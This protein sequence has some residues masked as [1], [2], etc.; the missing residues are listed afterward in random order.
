MGP[1]DLIEQWP[2]PRTGAGVLV[3]TSGPAGGSVE[4]VGTTGNLDTV[5]GWAS[6]TKLLVS[7]AVLVTCDRDKMNLDDPAGPPGAT[8]RH[9]LSHASGLG[10][11]SA[12]PLVEPGRRRIYSNFGIEVLARH[13]E[14]RSSL[15][16]ADAVSETVTSPL[17]M[18]TMEFPPD[19]SAAWSAKG[20]VRDLLALGRELLQPTIVSA[21]TVELA[22]EVAFPGLPGVV[23]GVGRYE[24]CVWGLGFELKGEKRPHWTPTTASPRTFGHFGRSGAFIWVDPDAGVAC[25][26]AGGAS[27]GNWALEEWPRFGDAVLAEWGRNDRPVGDHLQGS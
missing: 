3:R 2:D 14:D 16:W 23:P 27:F 6:V 11:D 13:L 4:L 19:G 12:E 26:S 7:L 1:F 18:A 21:A 15:N 5:R 25:V 22:T 20:T 17:A 10:P 9:L 8:V 24:D